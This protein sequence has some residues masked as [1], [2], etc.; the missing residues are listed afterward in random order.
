[1]T[2]NKISVDELI[3]TIFAQKLPGIRKQIE[4][5]IERVI[6]AAIFNQTN[7]QQVSELIRAAV[8]TQVNMLLVQP[9]FQEI[10]R[11]VAAKKIT[12]ALNRRE[13]GL[14]ADLLL[15]NIVEEKGE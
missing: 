15:P 11:R 14:D 6:T 9:N 7:T 10:V 4:Y 1:M 5:D 12:R 8:K 2:E 3:Q 13:A